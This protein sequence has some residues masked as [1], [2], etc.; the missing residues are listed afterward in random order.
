MHRLRDDHPGLVLVHGGEHH[1]PGRRRR[2][3][4]QLEPAEGYRLRHP[5]VAGGGRFGVHVEPVRAVGLFGARG[6]PPHG[7]GVLV[8][9]SGRG[10]HLQE[11]AVMSVR[12]QLRN[13]DAK[14]RKHSSGKKIRFLATGNTL[15]RNCG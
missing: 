7:G 8:A 4:R 14:R 5:M 13:L 9:A 1:V 12:V 2:G 10:D 3:V 15:F 6:R 11:D